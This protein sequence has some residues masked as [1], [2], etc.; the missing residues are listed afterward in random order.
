MAG[1]FPAT[2][3]ADPE[4]Q[5]NWDAL[6]LLI[7]NGTSAPLRLVA[8]AV[9]DAAFNPAPVDGTLGLDTVNLRLY[10]RIAGAWHYVQLI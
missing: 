2:V 5:L 10:A 8:G 6:A 4:A 1:P 3:V 7:N 9:T